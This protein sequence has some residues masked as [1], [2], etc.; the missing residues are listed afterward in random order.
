MLHEFLTNPTILNPQ[1]DYL[2]FLQNL[3]TPELDILFLNIT[4]LA[5]SIMPY[6]FVSLCY[7]L[8]DKRTGFILYTAMQLGMMTKDFLKEIAFV[9]RPWLLSDRVH[10]VEAAKAHAPGYSFPSGHTVR[11]IT[12]IAGISIAEWNKSKWLSLFFILLGV[13]VLFSRNYLGVHTPQDVIVGTL[14]SVIYLFAATKFFN[15]IDK[16][17]KGYLIFAGFVLILAAIIVTVIATGIIKEELM[18]YYSEISLLTGVCIGYYIDKKYI[19][20]EIP[21]IKWYKK[22]F[23]A[24]IGVICL[25]LLMHLV[26]FIVSD[27]V[28]DVYKRIIMYFLIS[29]FSTIIYPL[30]IKFVSKKM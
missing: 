17:E 16:K 9:K 28:F 19:K 3:R 7:W 10:P 14:F 2:V 8:L 27:T 26:Y 5:E 23:V 6:I 18:S 13:S 21:N 12:S 30:F 29:I 11:G 24:I 15:W 1:I 4:K 20:Y 25:Y 22:I